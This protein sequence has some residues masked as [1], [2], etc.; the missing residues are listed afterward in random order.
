M[1]RVFPFRRVAL[2][3]FGVLIA[4]SFV[5]TGLA[6]NSEDNPQGW[7]WDGQS[8]ETMTFD[9]A[10][11][12]TRFFFADMPVFDD[13]MPA[14]GNPFVTEGYIYPAGTLNGTNGV[15]ADGS[16]E[17]PDKVIGTWFC[18]GYFVGDG[19]HAVSG[20]FVL[21]SQILNFGDEWG[22]V[23]LITE[24]FE[25]ID[26]GVVIERAVTGGTG[27]YEAARGVANQTLLGFN[28]T[29]GANLQYESEVYK[30]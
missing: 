25:L 19:M 11:N 2:V 9:V 24:G 26:V 1:S 21:T 10:E 16:P 8:R 22:G 6:A 12:G 3:L 20:P 18:R 29:M 5:V 4:S 27:P 30:R 17:F 15:L 7:M 23:T 14:A 28:G 13:G